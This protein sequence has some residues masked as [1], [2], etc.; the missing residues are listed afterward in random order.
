MIHFHYGA[1]EDFLDVTHE[2]FDQCF[3]GRRV[4][5]PAGD[6]GD[7]FFPDPRV[8]RAKTIVVV[9]DE[10]G[11]Q[12][13]RQYYWAEKVE[14]TLTEDEI[15]EIG[16]E[17]EIQADSPYSKRI[18][19]PPPGLDTAEQI[20]FYHAQLK[21]AGGDITHE[22]VEQWLV[23]DY[24]NPD[25]KVLELGSCI[26]RNT[27]M[28][29]CVLNDERNLVTLECNPVNIEMLRN[30]RFANKLR[31]HIEPSALSY[32]KLMQVRDLA[33]DLSWEALP[34]EELAEGYEWVS[35][36]TFEELLE[37]YKLEFDTLVADCEGALYYILQDNAKMLENISLIILESDYR[38]AEHK[39]AVEKIFA[40]YGLQ[41]IHSD[42]L[43]T[44]LTLPQECADSFWEVWKRSD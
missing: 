11:T 43:A 22:M 33:P 15:R 31:F 29:S 32:R 16:L 24:L 38:L 35:T 42:A 28:I 39:W 18:V 14:I 23:V 36:I 4:Y 5:I 25:A 9:R 12:T 7:A 6:T 44:N 21:C 2:V 27:M 20:D 40:D 30:N 1:G 19:P 8:G 13:C 3:D 37:K 10:A 41:K 17:S 34:A 26:G